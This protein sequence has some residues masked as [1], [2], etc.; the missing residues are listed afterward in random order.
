MTR[1]LNNWLRTRISGDEKS[2]NRSVTAALPRKGE[3]SGLFLENA[4]KIPDFGLSSLPPTV[5]AHQLAQI[6]DD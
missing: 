5:L 3:Y 4:V 6:V 2:C 1:L